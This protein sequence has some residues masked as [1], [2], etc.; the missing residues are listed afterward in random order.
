MGPL[1]ATVSSSFGQLLQLSSLSH[2][3]PP[4]VCPGFGL[5][6]FP[7]ILCIKFFNRDKK[8]VGPLVSSKEKKNVQKEGESRQSDVQLMNQN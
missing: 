2:A 8:D 5:G 3:C 4:V 1:S 7:S 6:T